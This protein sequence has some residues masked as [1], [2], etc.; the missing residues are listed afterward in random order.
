MPRCFAES[1]LA[2]KPRFS[3]LLLCA[4]WVPARSGPVAAPE[5]S[6]PMIGVA[7]A[8]AEPGGIAKEDDVYTRIL[9][10]ASKKSARQ[11]GVTEMK[12]G[13]AATRAGDQTTAVAAFERAAEKFPGLADWARVLGAQAAARKG[14][15]V[16]VRRLL[17]GAEPV[18]SREWGWRALMDAR[19][20]GGDV[21][22]ATRA[23]E[24]AADDI[25]DATLRAGAIRVSGEIH[26]GAGDT[27]YARDAFRRTIEVAPGSKH[28]VEAARQLAALRG[29][30]ADDHLRIGRVYVRHG[31]IER[32]LAGFDRYLASGTGT[33][34]ER[35]R[36]RFESARVL[37]DS[38]RY[39]EAEKHLVALTSEKLDPATGADA[40]L[41]LGRAQYRQKKLTAARTTLL[42]TAERHP[43]QRAASEALF[44]VADIDHD[45]GDLASARS[46]Y[47]R[48]IGTQPGGAD[49]A[50]AAMRLGGMEF[51]SGAFTRAATIFDDY[52]A[53]HREG[54]RYQ[55]ACYWAARAWLEAGDTAAAMLR[56]GEAKRVDPTSYYGI[57]AADMT[58]DI[59]WKQSLAP[60][61]VTAA[62]ATAEAEGALARLDMLNE[63]GLSDAAAYEMDHIKR[64]FNGREGALYVIGESY[65]ARG[66]T[67]N[68]IRIGREILRQEGVWNARLL[69]IVYP[70]PYRDEVIAQSRRRG[71][72]PFLVA[73]LIRQESMFNPTAVSS[74][75]AIGLMQIMPKTGVSLGRRDGLKTVSKQSLRNPGVN[76][77]LGT[78]FVSDLLQRYGGSMTHVLAAYNAGS[79]RV[80]RWRDQ[81]EAADPDMFAERIPFS[82]TR[83][84]VKIVQQN[85]R[86]YRALYADPPPTAPTTGR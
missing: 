30:S 11:A 77:R 50:E 58:G 6:P 21:A 68:G 62:A 32:G 69:R 51:A 17:S 66:E 39:V 35:Q 37:F 70:F 47:A 27:A 4:F 64:H 16:A 48:A 42:A 20:T 19:R 5:S 67:F 28:A 31:N 63:L 13:L 12:R 15:T 72:D 29:V 10:D 33:A 46:L 22:G 23:A 57:R 18:L 8:S 83:E 52:R 40:G 3:L 84:Y 76:I 38:R 59:P 53:T 61:P 36:V 86:M 78:L 75:G 43:D 71:I 60:S 82:E 9:I 49:A 65:H 73:G 85:R 55:Q 41:L 14:D 45:A 2:M 74:A 24:H 34:S 44:I 81:P 56:L 1:D 54:A 80:A 7:P 25:M 79:S 26:L